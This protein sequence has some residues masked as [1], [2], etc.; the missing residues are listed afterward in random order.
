VSARALKS[1]L[2]PITHAVRACR[3][4]TAPRLSPVR[5][6]SWRDLLYGRDWYQPDGGDSSNWAGRRRRVDPELFFD[7][8]D[9]WISSGEPAS[10]VY[11]APEK[12]HYAAKV[13]PD[14][15]ALGALPASV[16]RSITIKGDS[17]SV[18]ASTGNVWLSQVG[19]A[20]APPVGEL[21]RDFISRNSE[22]V[23]QVRLN[24]LRALVVFPTLVLVVAWLWVLISTKPSP[25][26]AA[27]SGMLTIAAC[28]VFSS[29]LRRALRNELHP[30]TGLVVRGESRAE[31]RAKREK[32]RQDVRIALIT[33]P[34][35]AI[36]GA[37]LTSVFRV[38][39]G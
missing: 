38:L 8:R 14:A 31:T 32:T 13:V 36:L 37:M 25:S 9:L 18:S 3:E 26:L 5:L 6:P 4:S 10:V 22:P 15:A 12:D 16:Q 1:R 29:Q 23:A 28:I 35:G 21:T 39:I 34:I 19:A 24:A 17:W 33:L 27:F 20:K 30:R 2:G 7:I 11:P